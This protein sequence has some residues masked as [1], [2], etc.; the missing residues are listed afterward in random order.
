MVECCIKEGLERVAP[1]FNF[2][3]AQFIIPGGLRLLP[4]SSIVPPGDLLGKPFGGTRCAL[5]RNGDLHQH[6]LVL[7]CRESEKRADAVIHAHNTR[8]AG[9]VTD[10]AIAPRAKR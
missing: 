1:T 5:K 3:L 2:D 4:H 10:P 8:A 7:R 6:L 9:T